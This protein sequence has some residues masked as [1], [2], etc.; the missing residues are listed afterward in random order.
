MSTIYK[1][2]IKIFYGPV[3]ADHRLIPAPDIS[4]STQINYANDTII[5]YTYTINL[6]GVVTA[7]DLRNVEDGDAYDEPEHYN[8]GAI[9][10]HMHKL[11]QILSQNGNILRILGSGENPA[12]ILEASGGILRSLNFSESDNNWTHYARYEASIEFNTLYLAGNTEGCGYPFISADSYASNASGTVDISQFKIKSFQD[13]WS[14]TFDEN[15]AYERNQLTDLYQN[16]SINNN[17]FN[18]EYSISATGKNHYVYDTENS[19][20]SKL[21]P[22]WE[23]AK[24]FVQNRLYYQVT[25]LINGV[26]KNSDTNVCSP[27]GSLSSMNTPGG[28]D[29]LL[30]SLGDSI[31]SIFNE[32]ITCEASESEGTFSANYTATVKSNLGKLVI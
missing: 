8:T 1:P 14:F 2:D 15:E 3:D 32:Q 29:G 19:D 10:D 5:G 22:A 18:I 31:Y 4:I 25:S 13:S 24:N 7:L 26:L 27:L 23:Q 11:R 17:S 9:A 28:S 6:T 12:N 16:L 20:S 21:L 30:S